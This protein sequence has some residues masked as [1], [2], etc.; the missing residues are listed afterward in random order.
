[1]KTA[2]KFISVLVVTS[3]SSLAYADAADSKTS[4]RIDFN[5]MID[6][7]NNTRVTLHKDI[8]Q[9]ATAAVL[10]EESEAERAKVVTL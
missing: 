10:D 1:M 8:D 7:N 5:K 2:L 9:K 4:T 3:V 6:D